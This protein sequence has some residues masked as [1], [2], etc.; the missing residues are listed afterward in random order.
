MARILV[1]DDESYVRSAIGT[2]LTSNAFGPT[3][4]GQYI[5]VTLSAADP[6]L[7]DLKRRIEEM[8]SQIA[9]LA[10]KDGKA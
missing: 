8:Q 3:R 10:S 1:I 2:A 4:G 6:A 5:V 9:K 7:D